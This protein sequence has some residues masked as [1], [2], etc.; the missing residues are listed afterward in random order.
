MPNICQQSA[1]KYIINVYYY[2]SCYIE[3]K[4]CTLRTFAAWTTVSINTGIRSDYKMIPYYLALMEMII[5]SRKGISQ[6]RKGV[7]LCVWVV[8]EFV[9]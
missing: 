2:C 8:F 4:G 6:T 3:W 5:T 7:K 9:M 1:L